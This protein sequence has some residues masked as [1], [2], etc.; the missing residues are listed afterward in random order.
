M[1]SLKPCALALCRFDFAHCV[2]LRRDKKDALRL[3]L[4]EAAAAQG[5]S[6]GAMH[7]IRYVAARHPRSPVVWNAYARAVAC[8]GSMR[9][10]L[11][12]LTGMRQKFPDSLPLMVLLGNSY[13]IGVGI[14]QSLL[15]LLIL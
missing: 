8:S 1:Q 11:R 7:Q 9:P 6:A 10:A 5:D 2:P 3:V 13:T 14:I 15:L 12:H 4:S